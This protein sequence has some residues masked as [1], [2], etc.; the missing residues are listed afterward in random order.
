[1][2]LIFYERGANRISASKLFETSKA[3]KVPVSYFFEG[4]GEGEGGEG[5]TETE[6]EQFVHGFLM[7]SEGIELAEAFPRIK[8]SKHRR[9]ILDLVRSLA[10]D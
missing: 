2:A 10:E 7:T 1:M 9:K 5:F 8:S 4:Y 6:F 3:L